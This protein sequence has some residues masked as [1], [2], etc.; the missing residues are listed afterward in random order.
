M[1][2]KQ[3]KQNRGIGVWRKT[4]YYSQTTFHFEN[5]SQTIEELCTGFHPR[6]VGAG[7]GGGGFS[8]RKNGGS[9]VRPA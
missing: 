3:T 2:S 9:T 7:G 1:V 8:L 4:R 5:T 6:P